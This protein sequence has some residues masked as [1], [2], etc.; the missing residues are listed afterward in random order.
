MKLSPQC[1]LVL[2][3]LRG[4]WPAGV[5]SHDFRAEYGVGDPAKRVCELKDAGYE[6]RTEQAN[7]GKRNG[8][9]YILHRPEYEANASPGTSLSGGN[10][11]A[12]RTSSPRRLE[13]AVSASL[14]LTAGHSSNDLGALIAGA[15]R[16]A[17]VPSLASAGD[18]VSLSAMEEATRRV[19]EGC[20]ELDLAGRS[21][22]APSFE[23]V[24]LVAEQIERGRGQQSMEAAA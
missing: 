8:V 14:A 15:A 4:A 12:G 16:P 1:R 13:P 21:Y 9:L 3:R 18:P 7:R 10:E 23:T 24:V 19:K 20:R 22:E 5:H 17:E 2:S 11:A 6:I